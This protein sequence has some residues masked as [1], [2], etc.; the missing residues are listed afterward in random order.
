MKKILISTSSFGVE[1]SEPLRLLESAG[2]EFSLNPH[3]RKLSKEETIAL[4]QDKDGVIAG[5]ES[6]PKEV[7]E[8][9]S[10]LKVIS[11]C[12]AG[13]DGIDKNFLKQSGITLLNTPDVHITAVAELTLAGLLSLSRKIALNHAV[14]ISGK[15]EKFMGTNIS[16]K[17]VGLIGFGKVGQAVARLLSGFGCSILVYDPYFK[18]SPPAGCCVVTSLDEIWKQADVI[19]LH[20]PSTG[21][22]KSLINK[23]VLAKVKPDVILVNT[24]RGDLVDESA[25]YDFLKDHAGAGAYLDVFQ[26][27]PYKGPLTTLPNIV[28]TPHVGTFTRETRVNMEVESVVNLINYFKKS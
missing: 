6:Y 22:T 10:S 19:S 14:M 9:L 15:W 23:E 8:K 20:I 16:S 25:L 3:G 26:Q 4:L 17:T 2:V 21:E 18:N 1:S 13:T 11:R 7:V 27:E 28:L 12:G 24:S 5:T